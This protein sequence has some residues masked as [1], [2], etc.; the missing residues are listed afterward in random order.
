MKILSLLVGS[1]LFVGLAGA[2]GFEKYG[3]YI[4]ADTVLIWNTNIYT[5]CG[6]SYAPQATLVGDSIAVI[7]NDT[8]HAHATC[9]CYFDVSVALWNV[10]AG[11]YRVYL[12]RTEEIGP[13]RDTT[14]LV[15]SFSFSIG[16]SPIGTPV[17]KATAAPCHQY[18]IQSVPQGMLPN[19]FAML[20]AYPNPFNPTT[21]IRYAI[22]RGGPVK[23]EVYD[24]V[25]RLVRTLLNREEKAGTYETVFDARDFASGVYYCRLT[26]AGQTLTDRLMLVK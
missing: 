11:S 4:T 2:Q 17:T 7:E 19:S 12:F 18:P 13:D 3:A 9:D 15:A 25:G 26:A 20:A 5:T 14:V 16:G 22:P 23:V 10:P 21:T 24:A 6:T 8:S 1:F